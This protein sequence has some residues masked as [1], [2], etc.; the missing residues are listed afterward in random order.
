MRILIICRIAWDT[1]RNTIFDHAFS[2][3]KYDKENEYFY[4][5]AFNGRHREDYQWIQEKTFDAVIFHYTVMGLRLLDRFFYNFTQ[6]MSEI[7]RNKDCVKIVMPQDDYVYTRQIWNFSKAIQ[8]D[9]ILSITRDK[10]LNE[11]YPR[12]MINPATRVINVL[13]GY[14]DEK[15]IKEYPPHDNRTYDLMY[16]ARKLPYESGALGLK[17][18]ELVTVFNDYLKDKA[19]K[20]NIAN[21]QGD[22]NSYM[23]DSWID[24]LADTRCIIGCLGGYGIIDADYRYHIA[25]EEYMKQHPCTSYEEAKRILYPDLSDSLT[26]MI[27]PRIFEAALT[28]TCQILVG[29]D[30]QGILAPGHDY[31]VLNEDYSNIDEVYKKMMDIAYCKHIAENAFYTVTGGIIK[32]KPVRSDYTYEAFVNRVIELIRL[33]HE[34]EYPRD[35]IMSTYIDACCE[36]NNSIVN[37]EID[38]LLGE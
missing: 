5:N 16:R 31:I 30:Y 33:R 36:R 3:K 10:D 19:G 20:F 18:Y 11:M 6:L 22:T 28:K 12:Q 2:F 4:F 9:Y 38:Q 17:K 23:G 8:A 35:E 34:R 26:G 24:A 32:G 27:S 37:R 7:F 14:I 13:T 21:T 15:Y 29:E 25:Y 1:K